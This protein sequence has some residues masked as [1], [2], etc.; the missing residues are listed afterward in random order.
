MAAHATI[1]IIGASWRAEYF[2]RAAAALPDR[3]TVKRVLVQSDASAARVAEKWAVAATT[4][5]DDFLADAPYDFVVITTPPAVA[6]DLT[7]TVAR[8]GI[9]VLTE[10]PPALDVER[11]FALYA[12]LRD[13]PVQVAEQY[14]YQPHHAVR[15]SVANSGVLGAINS[16]RMSVAHGY[17]GISLIR[18]FL[19]AGFEPVSISASAFADPAV[20]ARGRDNWHEQYVEYDSAR[21]FAT[22]QFGSRVGHY[23]FDFEQYFSPIRSRHIEVYGSKGQIHD[24]AI[25]YLTAPGRATTTRIEREAT[26][27]D[28]DLE[29]Y[30]LR[31]LS[32]GDT[33]HWSNKYQPARLNDDELAVTEVMS[34]MAEFVTVG[35][36]FYPLADGCHDQ[37]LS[38]RL[39]ESAASGAT[40]EVGTDLPWSGETSIVGAR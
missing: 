2:L 31:S 35:E 18:L 10:T 20:S 21:T 7:T 36:P 27:A 15:L 39:N 22:L 24:D 8:A 28:G 25:S 5:L 12:D 29:G 37:Y 40:I 1:G 33:T 6:P 14:Q 26:G 34:R 30:F 19:G 3:F 11:L 4:S 13:L 9:P 32:V 23:E 17:H 38:L 16:T